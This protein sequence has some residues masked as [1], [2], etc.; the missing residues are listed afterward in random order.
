MIVIIWYISVSQSTDKRFVIF[1]GDLSPTGTQ[2]ASDI[3]S[4]DQL[5]SVVMVSQDKTNDDH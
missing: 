4:C 5:W 2:L 3:F 1:L